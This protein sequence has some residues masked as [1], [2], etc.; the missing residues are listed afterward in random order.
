MESSGTG[1]HQKKPLLLSRLPPVLKIH[2]VHWRFSHGEIQASVHSPRLLPSE[3]MSALC[4][5]SCQTFA[6]K[7]KLQ[8][9]KKKNVNVWVSDQF[10]LKQNKLSF[11][12]ATSTQFNHHSE[13]VTSFQLQLQFIQ[14]TGSWNSLTHSVTALLLRESTLQTSASLGQSLVGSCVHAST[15]RL[16]EGM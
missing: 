6:S 5:F 9:L 2:Q 12:R 13:E 7:A 14:V 15:L 4:V 8:Y 1:Q 11:Y 3:G 16:T 10:V